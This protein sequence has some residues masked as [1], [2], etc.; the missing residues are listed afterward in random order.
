MT[1]KINNFTD[2]EIAAKQFQDAIVFAYNENCP[3]TVRRN[4]RDTSRWNQDLAEKRR[5]VQKLFNTAKM[6]GNWTDYKRS[7][8][9][10]NKTLRQAKRESWRRQCEEIEKVPESGRLRRIF[11]KDIQ[12]SIS[13][14][15]LENGDYATREKGAMEELLRV[16]FPG[17]KIISEPSG[18]WDDLELEF[19]KRKGSR[20]PWGGVQKCH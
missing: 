1:D 11:S 16:H 15:Q 8:T 13:S 18:G 9:N 3:L 19:P 10:Y 5:K 14:I 20:G 17:L 4:N 12:S 7:L 6:S 2:L